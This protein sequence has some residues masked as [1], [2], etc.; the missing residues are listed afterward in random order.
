[1]NQLWPTEWKSGNL[2]PVLK[3]DDD[4][5]KE[6]YRPVSIL[7]AIS[8]V[9]EKVMFDQLYGAFHEHL[10][11]NLSGFLKKHSCC[12]A[13]LKM[14]EDWR[15]SLDKRESVIAVAVDL[16]KAFDS[17][18]HNLLLA[19]LKAYG[20]S[21]SALNLISSYLLGRRQ[22]VKLSGV[23]SSYSEVMVGVPQG[24][25]LGPLL[26]NIYINDLNYAIPDVS[27][28]LY[29]DD[30]TMYASDVSPM[31]LE[32]VVNNGLERL[33]SWFR[34]NH[35]VINNTKT[36][37]VPI[38]PCKYSY[39]LAIHSSV[40]ETLPSIKILGV[41]LDSMLS[42]KDHITKQLQKL[43]NG[44]PTSVKLAN[45]INLFKKLLRTLKL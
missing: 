24:S 22:R 29:A 20:S 39:D 14:T 26:F 44:L 17:I 11:P 4:T 45:D 31:V 8:K 25:L 42:F 27:L 32:F 12:T 5:R 9:Y 23:C 7:T 38:G 33:S 19:K 30:T 36:Q 3:K 18:N 21:P 43:W 2:T 10:S 41:E 34:E 37:A 6:N 16:S 15:R 13:L 28:R 40:I 35:L 1:M